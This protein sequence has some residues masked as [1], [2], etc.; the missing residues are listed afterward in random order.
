MLLL[1]LKLPLLASPVFLLTSAVELLMAS[2]LLLLLAALLLASL[3]A[4]LSSLLPLLWS[5]SPPSSHLLG[6]GFQGNEQKSCNFRV[7]TVLLDIHLTSIV[8]PKSALKYL[9]LVSCTL[10]SIKHTNK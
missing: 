6:A 9:I 5:A 4:L 10:N 1:A 3:L 2:V 7:I 8:A